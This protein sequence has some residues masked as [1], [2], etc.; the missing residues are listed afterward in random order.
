MK[1][2]LAHGEKIV[3][4]SSQG[5]VQE[6]HPE[7]ESA[8]ATTKLF[9]ETETQ[10]QAYIASHALQQAR[11][12]SI[13]DTLGSLVSNAGELVTGLWNKLKSFLSSLWKLFQWVVY[14]FKVAKPVELIKNLVVA[15]LEIA[16][17]QNT[18]SSPLYQ[19]A[20]ASLT[21][22]YKAMAKALD[23][24]HTDAALCD[25]VPEAEMTGPKKDVCPEDSKK[26]CMCN[27]KSILAGMLPAVTEAGDDTYPSFT[28]ELTKSILDQVSSLANMFRRSA[29]SEELVAISTT[30][31]ME[32]VKTTVNWF[33]TAKFF[34]VYNAQ[35]VALR[36]AEDAAKKAKAKGQAPAAIPEGSTVLT[37]LTTEPKLQAEGSEGLLQFVEV[38]RGAKA[39]C[40]ARLETAV[41]AGKLVGVRGVSEEDARFVTSSYDA[42]ISTI[43]IVVDGRL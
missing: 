43:G 10:I 20:M 23:G 33:K 13:F 37:L 31:M 19:S 7:S 38:L 30:C 6:H 42:Y 40:K 35:K 17:P 16:N 32:S 18:I 21:E 11:S 28:S 12:Q 9:L 15:A 25:P 39:S 24:D 41:A 34:E 29:R 2:A 1:T 3:T 27:L 36:D 5:I 4:S 8:K 22:R 14:F 26:E